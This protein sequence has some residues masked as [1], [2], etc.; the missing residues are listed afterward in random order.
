LVI[1]LSVHLFILVIV[2]SVHLFILVI[3]LCVHLRVS[4]S[5]YPLIYFSFLSIN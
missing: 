4:T 3:V 1:V 2:L 5:D